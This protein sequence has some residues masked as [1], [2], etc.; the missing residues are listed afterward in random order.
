MSLAKFVV[1]PGDFEKLST[2]L[3]GLPKTVANKVLAKALRAGGNI[4]ANEVKVR[5]PV[6][7]DAWQR[8]AVRNH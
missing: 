2:G 7:R 6:D 8:V 1:K 5:A 4:I 3:K